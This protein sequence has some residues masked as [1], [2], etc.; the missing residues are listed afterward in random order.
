M[1]AVLPIVAPIFT[2]VA[3]GY[4]AT[5]IGWFDIGHRA[6]LSRFVFRFAIP[7]LLFRKLSTV[8]LPELSALSYLLGYYGS[9]LLSY[10]LV[11]TVSRRVLN[12]G[13]Q[14]AALHGFA[15]C[16]SNTV[17]LG[18]PLILSALGED[19][20]LPL[21]LL[22]SLHSFVLFSVVTVSAE[23][24]EPGDRSRWRALRQGF[25]GLTRNPILLGLAAG[26]AAN[27]LGLTLPGWLDEA[28]RTLSEAALPAALFILG[29]ALFD[30]GVRG[31]VW[32]SLGI[33][34]CKLVLHPLLAW[35]IVHRVLGFDGVWLHTAVILASLPTGVNVYLFAER[36]RAAEKTVAASICLSMALAVVTLPVLLLWLGVGAAET[37]AA[38]INP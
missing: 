33:I 36:Y 3:L 9:A 22:I 32:P 31:A 26:I 27:L 4:L 15:A 2:L 35:L 34:A 5:W 8:P 38:R 30:Y 24:A 19:A 23:F 25:V 1:S 12:S 17:L 21:F 13:G 20:S 6:G 10:A 14:Q 11:L 7:T 16:F 18:I 29:A 37:G 28:A